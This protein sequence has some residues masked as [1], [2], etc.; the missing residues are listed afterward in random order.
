MN[1]KQEPD[2]LPTRPILRVTAFVLAATSVGVTVAWL[3]QG[4]VHRDLGRRPFTGNAKPSPPREVSAVEMDL[5]ASPA[6][7]TAADLDGYEW[8]DRE[9]GVV[10]IPMERAFDLYLDAQGARP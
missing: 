5:F 8:V 4:A 10:S 1:P 3:L 2:I 7:G 6:R 9:A